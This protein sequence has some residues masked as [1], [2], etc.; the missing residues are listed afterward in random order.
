[1]R[2]L[3][4]LVAVVLCAPAGAALRGTASQSNTSSANSVTVTNT[5]IGI[6]SG[7]FLVLCAMGDTG[8]GA[9]WTA[10]T[11]FSA[12]SG[13]GVIYIDPFGSTQALQCFTK[14][15]GG[16][17][18][19]TYTLTYSTSDL[20]TALLYDFS[21][22]SGSITAVALS[23]VGDGSSTPNTYTMGSLT[24]AAGD[25]IVDIVGNTR[26]N[27][28][29]DTGNVTCTPPSGYS[30]GLAT[31]SS[32]LYSPIFCSWTKT[33]STAGAQSTTGGIYS[34]DATS[35]VSAYGGLR[36][37]LAQGSGGGTTSSPLLIILSE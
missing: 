34:T 28:P 12:I 10:P 25:D 15:A 26:W 6:Q 13:A 8:S 3:A 23:S 37:S 2:F 22:R 14:T 36:L 11:G 5:S 1:M 30:N 27:G 7:D 29:S 17:E 31:Y 21:G 18:A 35:F 33:N 19:S 24:A 16:S 4:F 20:I 32:T 9:T